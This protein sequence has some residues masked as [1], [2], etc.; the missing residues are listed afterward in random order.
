MC[1]YLKV[2]TVVIFRFLFILG[3]PTWLI[4]FFIRLHSVSA[5]ELILAQV[6]LLPPSLSLS[7][8]AQARVI[9]PVFPSEQS[10]KYNSSIIHYCNKVS[11]HLPVKDFLV[12][13]LKPTC[14]PQQRWQYW[15][16]VCSL[17]FLLLIRKDCPLIKLQAHRP[18]MSQLHLVLRWTLC[19]THN[20]MFLKTKQHVRIACYII[21]PVLL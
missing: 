8:T 15:L 11:R 20:L 10:R 9:A 2:G 3:N 4:Y 12:C 13:I 19:V 16:F 7:S 18:M 17:L 21:L 14:T 1:W 6:Y 5:L